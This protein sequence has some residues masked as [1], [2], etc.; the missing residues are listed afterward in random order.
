M[1]DYALW[2]LNGLGYHLQNLFWHI[3][4]VLFVYGFIV[5]LGAKPVYALMGT[6]LYAIH[7]QRVESV[8]WIAERKDVLCGAFYFG[9]IYFFLKFMG[10]EERESPSKLSPKAFSAIFSGMTPAFFCY[11]LAIL[12]KPMAISLPLILL[13]L[14]IYRRKRFNIRFT[15]LLPFFLIGL[16]FAPITFLTNV[17]RPESILWGR[18][19]YILSHNIQWYVINSFSVGDLCPM[20]PKVIPSGTRLFF[21][22]VFY[23]L[24][25]IVI[26]WLFARQR[27]CLLY[28]VL[29]YLASF[30][31][32]LAPV[33]GFIP[34]SSI[35]YADRYSYIPSVFLWALLCVC[36]TRWRRSEILFHRVAGVL[37]VCFI[38]YWSLTNI[39]YAQTWKNYES[40]LRTAC[41]RQTANFAP[42]ISLA[43]LSF[44]RGA[45]SE[46]LSLT[47]R[48]LTRDPGWVDERDLSHVYLMAKYLRAATFFQ[49][50]RWELSRPILL[51]LKEKLDDP[52]F[53]SS[54]AAKDQIHMMIEKVDE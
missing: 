35:D 3:V 14:E 38:V 11:V 44:A 53:K 17:T 2:G 15:R 22:L 29:P 34:W 16:A 8:V 23:A 50:G 37:C 1:F 32:S 45:H 41:E 19:L 51:E 6:L 27:R 54:P 42:L 28:V 52:A 12:S 9:A 39:I 24:C 20:Y 31:L 47:E 48:V 7:P 49:A 33:A 10:G 36:V 5:R 25:L 30:L 4:A 26:G 21:M 40:I 43:N 46:T 18:R 13:C